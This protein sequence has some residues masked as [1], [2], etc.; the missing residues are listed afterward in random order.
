[1]Y[2]VKCH[3]N[4]MYHSSKGMMNIK[5][6]QTVLGPVPVESLGHCQMHEHLYVAAGPATQK[7]PALLIDD[8][9][10]S[11][12]EL[13]DYRR[14]GGV[15]LLDAQPGGAGRNA[16]ILKEISIQSGI[17][18]ITVTGYHL[19]HFYPANHWLLTENI[20]EQCNRFR[21]ELSEGCVE[22]PEVRPGAVKAA[23]GPEGCAGRLKDCFQAAAMAAGEA[24]VPLIVHTEKGAGAVEAVRLA[25]AVGVP[26][27]RVVICH[28]DRQAT[29]YAPHDAI[30][31]TG[32]MLEYDTIGRFKY[33]DD[34]SEIR[35]IRH[36]IERGHA[37]QLLISLDTTRERLKRYGGSIGLT[38][39][40]TDFLPALRRSGISETI[41]RQI[42]VGN[43]QKVFS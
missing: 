9:V 23:L 18:V 43:P 7:Y 14:V 36:M 5:G 4:P 28:A 31:D 20:D 26:A 37:H 24:D 1:M 21:H 30:A 34:D 11:E 8:P 3:D 33:H 39:L 32:A 6:V 22:A 15:S 41:I 25:Q 38:Y 19:P 13:A 10:R 2:A 17:S 12:E 27:H 16:A 42:T 35:L 29:D 40:L